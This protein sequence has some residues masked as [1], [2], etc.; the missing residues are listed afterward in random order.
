M[1]DPKA[2]KRQH[3]REAGLLHPQPERVRDPLFEQRPEF[4]DAE[5]RLQVRYEMLRAYLIDRDAVS[6]ICARYGI[7]RQTFY[8][9]QDKFTDQGTSGLLPKQPGPKGP[10]KLTAQVLNLV[11]KRLA[12]EQVPSTLELREEIQRQLGFALHRRTIEKLAKDLRAKK[13]PGRECRSLPFFRRR[14][15]SRTGML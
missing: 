3:L 11:R 4:F 5:D 15:R 6:A 7:S 8:N 2:Q 9:L 12:Q 13:T 14:D 1:S 10:R